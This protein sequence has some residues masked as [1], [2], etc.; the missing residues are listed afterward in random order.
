MSGHYDP[1]RHFGHKDASGGRTQKQETGKQV[2]F[3][4]EGHKVGRAPFRRL[5]SLAPEFFGS[6]DQQRCFEV[7]SETTLGIAWHGLNE[8]AVSETMAVRIARRN[9]G[10]TKRR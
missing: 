10:T 2:A 7:V 8:C 4:Q 1:K 5:L 3:L 9:W 6:F